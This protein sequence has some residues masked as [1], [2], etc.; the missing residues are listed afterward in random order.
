MVI[1]ETIKSFTTHNCILDI[2]KNYQKP[3]KKIIIQYNFVWILDK[4]KIW[5]L[6][7]KNLF[8]AYN[9][10]AESLYDKV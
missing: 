2:C 8:R 4:V 6:T 10:E 3:Y 9:A 5:C 7:Y 1:A